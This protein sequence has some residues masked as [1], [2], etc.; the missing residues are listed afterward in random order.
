LTK[1]K[2]K[3]PSLIEA[4][5]ELRFP[6]N[7]N[8][9]MS[10]YIKF[11]QKAEREGYPKVIDAGE[12]FQINFT[13]GEDQKP[14]FHPVSRRIQTWNKDDTQLWQASPNLFA[15]NRRAPYEGWEKFRPHI[16]K[17][18]E[19]YSKTAQPKKANLM[20][21]QYVNRITFSEDEAAAD[22]IEFMPPPVRYADRFE[23]F[24]CQ[25]QQAFGN[26]D[27]ILVSSARDLDPTR[28]V[29][30][31]EHVAIL[32]TITYSVPSPSLEKRTLRQLIENAHH[33]VI[34]SY[35]KSITDKQRE[36]MVQL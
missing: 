36:R 28:A 32:L 22:F 13:P 35:E 30:A 2:Y 14:E 16:L 17:G 10:S 34:E 21:L 27:R 33:R 20:V 23:S 24:V 25:T 31:K 19:I 1:A 9:G 15:A 11:A 29:D 7:N 3:H 18:I 8:W 26:G 5:F 12:G 4:V 6:D